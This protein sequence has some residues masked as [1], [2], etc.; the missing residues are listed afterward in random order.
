MI[1]ELSIYSLFTI[2]CLGFLLDCTFFFNL[3]ILFVAFSCFF[4]LRR[5]RQIF[6]YLDASSLVLSRLDYCNS[7]CFNFSKSTFYPLTKTFNSAA[8]LIS[9][10]LEFSHISPSL[11]DLYWLPLHF[12]FSFKICSL[13]YKISHSTSLSYLFNLLLLPKCAG[14]RSST[15]SQ[16]FIISR[17]PF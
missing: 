1:F 5:M 7:L 15:R 4:H 12:C 13:M 10:T 8:R 9:H 16:L 6:S 3:Q 14:L 2:C 11:V 17:S